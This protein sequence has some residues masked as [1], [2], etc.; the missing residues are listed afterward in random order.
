[1]LEVEE[2][3]ALGKAVHEDNSGDAGLT[4]EVP[5]STCSLRSWL[6]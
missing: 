1:M 4:T 3:E 5:L 2:L 6:V